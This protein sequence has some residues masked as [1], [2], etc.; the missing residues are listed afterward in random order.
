MATSQELNVQVS[1]GQNSMAEPIDQ[2]G[3]NS[4]ATPA[5]STPATPSSNSNATSTSSLN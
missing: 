5:T 3:V 1:S 2:K 4:P